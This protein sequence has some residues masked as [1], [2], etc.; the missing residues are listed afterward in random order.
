MPVKRTKTDSKLQ[1]RSIVLRWIVLILV[2]IFMTLIALFH[3]YPDIVG[4]TL[5]IDSFCPMGGLEGLFS[6]IFHG[7]FLQRLALG[8]FILLFAVVLLTLVYGRAFCGQICPLGTLQEIFGQIGRKKISKRIV[9]SSKQERIFRLLKYLILIVFVIGTWATG[10][11][12]IRAFDPWVAY[13]HVFSLEEMFEFPVGLGI[14]LISVIGALWLD[15]FF[16]KYLCPFGAFLGLLSPVG[17][18]G[19]S[20]NKETCIDC[21]KCDHV[22][23]M[24]IKVSTQQFIQDKEC[25]MC[26]ECVNVCPVE[27]TL[28]IASKKKT[29]VSSP[30]KVT[31]VS[32][33][34]MVLVALSFTLS[35]H[36]KWFFA[37]T[38]TPY[39]NQ[40]IK[41]DVEDIR[42]FMTL[43]ELSV[44]YGVP[45][46]VLMDKFATSPDDADKPIKEIV[47]E[48]EDGGHGTDLVRDFIR[49]YNP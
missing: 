29:V 42:G 46:E 11:L 25:I 36:F 22:C 30:M 45:L 23:P 16:C 32:I 28:I 49:N 1:K 43:R 48:D 9:H 34:L 6:W 17:I 19:I 35:G 39:E 27:D 41:N 24:N 31:I 12:I 14:L 8:S 4:R 13:A 3:Q 33:L 7:S 21:K 5:S 38:T 20:R 2:F 18:F 44:G 40:V 10:V 26:N 37:D 47:I 15:R